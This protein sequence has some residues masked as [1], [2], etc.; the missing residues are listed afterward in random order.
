MRSVAR[1]ITY[2]CIVAAPVAIGGVH[3]PVALGLALLGIAAFFSELQ[4]RR[5][6]ERFRQ[7][8]ISWTAIA[9]LVLGA[10]AFMQLIPFPRA[11]HELVSPTG[12]GF[13]ADGW[14]AAFGSEAPNTWRALS[15]DPG[16]TA[17]RAIRWVALAS[18]CAVAANAF[19]SRSSW[20]KLVFAIFASGY[21]VLGIGLIQRAFGDGKLLGFY[22][23]SVVLRQWSTFVNPNHAG[24]FFGFVALVGFA[25]AAARYQ[26]S[27]IETVAGAVTGLVFMI[28]MTF[29]QSLGAL[30]AFGA[31]ALVLSLGIAL[32]AAPLRALIRANRKMLRNVVL[33][34]SALL[35]A[36]VAAVA[37]LFFNGGRSSG[38]LAR[39]EQLEAYDSFMTK[40]PGRVELFTGAM[41][42]SVDF[43][44][45]GAGAGSVDRAIGPYLDW[46][47]FPRASVPTV[48]NELA[49]WIFT[50]G[51][52]AGL[53]AAGLIAW[54]CSRTVRRFIK[55]RLR[56]R[57]MLAAVSVGLYLI[58][59]AQIH[60]PFLVLG[61]GLP[62]VIFVVSSA[63]HNRK[64]GARSSN[65]GNQDQANQPSW[66]TR[67]APEAAA[68]AGVLAVVV[69]GMLH[70]GPY[71]D[72]L[73]PLLTSPLLSGDTASD[74]ANARAVE[75]IPSESRLYARLST[76]AKAAGE[77]DRALT[78]ARRAHRLKP[79]E[80]R[81]LFLA[82][83]AARA[84]D[85]E[86]SHKTYGEFFSTEWHAIPADA[87][88][89]LVRDIDTAEARAEIIAPSDRK[90]WWRTYD[91]IKLMEGPAAASGYALALA[92]HHPDAVNIKNMIIDAYLELEQLELAGMWAQTAIQDGLAPDE[93]RGLA[94]LIAKFIERDRHDQARAWL[95]RAVEAGARDFT[96]M[97]YVKRL[98]PTDPEAAT[99]QDAQLAQLAND[100]FCDSPLPQNHREDCWGLR[101]WL[102]ERDGQLDAAQRVYERIYSR[103]DRPGSLANFLSRHYRC[104]TLDSLATKAERSHKQ[105]GAARLFRKHA[106]RC[107]GD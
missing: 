66:L 15:L 28:V 35:L 39:L 75:L 13:F 41:R 6:P 16:Q 14:Q 107:A 79:D 26:K 3:F 29:Q 80:L 18:L 43:W 81:T 48:E 96:F 87:I 42:G 56:S 53:I 67:Y 4:H 17:D 91:T 9:F 52:P 20:R 40:L 36:A 10:V 46:A 47:T 64:S 84:G 73:G 88:S 77:F 54:S 12:T 99:E 49:E 34:A 44:L 68:G 45:T 60:F 37:T 27:P 24:V 70:W 102:L 82:R 55:L 57:R 74:E 21:V 2:I 106:E 95:E 11:L 32:Q 5:R 100:T 90:Y 38:L 89:S 62:M 94:S 85:D 1:T 72:P 61:A 63:S 22:E 76:S 103:L 69:C 30:M 59:V 25:F 104:G 71:A 105:K 31:A 101:A 93:G 83:A 98:V 50:L 58:L 65:G 78:L 86:L 33:G 97:R 92:E 19:R 51:M 23:P 8:H 7:I